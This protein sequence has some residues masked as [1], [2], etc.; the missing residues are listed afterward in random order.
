MQ[1][2]DKN[3]FM[4]FF[5]EF[6]KNQSGSTINVDG[7]E[8]FIN[9]VETEEENNVNKDLNK[10]YD[11]LY[12]KYIRLMAEFDNYRKRTNKE[13]E[14]IRNYGNSKTIELIIP[15]I[16]DF[17]RALDNINDDVTKEGVALIYN[18]F[19]STLTNLGLEKI[20]IEN[21]V[22]KFDTDIHDA[23]TMVNVKKK[24]LDKKIINCVQSGYKLNNKIIRHPKVIVGKYEN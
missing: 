4:D 18:K 14:D 17:E 7:V 19:I 1:N 9:D 10:D 23:V 24:K 11:L 13:K 21:N 22:T 15:I 20:D 3:N 8:P 2:K 5:S 12:D 16:D 6:M